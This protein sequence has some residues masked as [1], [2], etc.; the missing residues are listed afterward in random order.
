MFIKK[1][2][3]KCVENVL[4]VNI[5]LKCDVKAP[6]CSMTTNEKG[7]GGGGYHTNEIS[8]LTLKWSRPSAL[9]LVVKGGPYGP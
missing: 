1:L 8:S 6:P 5:I 3:L 2:A 7:K 4:I 9:P